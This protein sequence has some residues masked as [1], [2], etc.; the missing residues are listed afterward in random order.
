MCMNADLFST[1][2]YG[3]GVSFIRRGVFLWV[4]S[5]FF[6]FFILNVVRYWFDYSRR[7]GGY[8]RFG[9]VLRASLQPFQVSSLG[10]GVLFV[11][12]LVTVLLRINML[13]MGPYVFGVTCHFAFTIRISF[14]L[15]LR[16]FLYNSFSNLSVFVGSF[17]LPDLPLVG[18]MLMV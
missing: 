16:I 10:S 13:G 1:F 17:V 15:W 6:L 12:R 11:I 2:D 9:E 8:G 18:R 5:R 3:F 4:S 7:G 14:R